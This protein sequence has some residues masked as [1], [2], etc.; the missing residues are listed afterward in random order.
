MGEAEG[1]DDL[2]ADQ[3]GGSDTAMAGND[4]VLIADQNGVRKPELL[5]AV[6][7]LPDLA[8]RMLAGVTGVWLQ[9]VGRSIFQA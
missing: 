7:D 3:L 1:G 4:L 2:E 8:L 6:G 9:R 5:D